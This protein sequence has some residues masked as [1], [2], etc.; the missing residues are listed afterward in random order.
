MPWQHNAGIQIRFIATAQ[1]GTL[2]W[3]PLANKLIRV[4]VASLPP[5]LFTVSMFSE[6]SVI[7][8]AP[9]PLYERFWHV[10]W[11]KLLAAM[12][13]RQ[14]CKFQSLSQHLFS[15]PTQH[16]GI[17]S[18]ATM[19]T[20]LLKPPQSFQKNLYSQLSIAEPD[21]RSRRALFSCAVR[22]DGAIVQCGHIN[23]ELWLLTVIDSCS[24]SWN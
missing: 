22:G 3:P 12:L 6:P 19:L 23:C 8:E 7:R 4:N 14:P 20:R 2:V 11:L 15:S 13:T 1:Q 21:S 17:H 18:A 10:G 24:V 16:V 9:A 5:V